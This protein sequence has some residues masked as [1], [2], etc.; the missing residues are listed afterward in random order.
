MLAGEPGFE[1]GLA[2][3]ESAGLP[4]TYSPTR[5]LRSWSDLNVQGCA[6][7]VQGLEQV[8]ETRCVRSAEP[9]LLRGLYRAVFGDAT[10]CGR[11]FNKQASHA[12]F[13]GQ[14]CEK[15]EL[16][17]QRFPCIPA[18]CR[19]KARVT[20]P[21]LCVQTL[22]GGRFPATLDATLKNQPPHSVRIRRFKRFKP[23]GFG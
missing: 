2:E 15:A 1:P 14:L 12:R 7:L 5:Q 16:S 13:R 19:P 21:Y 4:L 9:L 17:K 11:F 18:G 20:G 10:A 6:C 22:A 23:Y 8:F 3:S